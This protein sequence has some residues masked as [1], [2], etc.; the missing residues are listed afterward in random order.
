MEKV[1]AERHDALA[2]VDAAH[3]GGF[4]GKPANLYGAKRDGGR[5]GI[6]DPHAAGLAVV[7]KRAKRDFRGFGRLRRS[8]PIG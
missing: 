2:G 1:G 5:M 3:D 4:L 8:P 7:I 6:E